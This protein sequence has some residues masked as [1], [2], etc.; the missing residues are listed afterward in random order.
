M[1]R[2]VREDLIP[3]GSPCPGSPRGHPLKR[4]RDLVRGDVIPA[5]PHRV[6][7]V[8]IKIRKIEIYRIVL[9]VRPLGFHDAEAPFDTVVYGDQDSL[10]EIEVRTLTVKEKP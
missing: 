9:S 5:C 10:I 4:V 8:V 7:C 3:C 2:W 6:R 1:I